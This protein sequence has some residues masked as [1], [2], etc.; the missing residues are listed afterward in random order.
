MIIAFLLTE[1][2]ALTP[3]FVMDAFA[4]KPLLHL[5]I[6]WTKVGPGILVLAL[7]SHSFFLTDLFGVDPFT[8]VTITVLL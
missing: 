4:N 2:I 1:I 7:K 3:A 8:G 5:G 6:A